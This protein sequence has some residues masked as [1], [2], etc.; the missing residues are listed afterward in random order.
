MATVG[1]AERSGPW[2][3]VKNKIFAEDEKSAQFPLAVTLVNIV[4]EL[5]ESN[6]LRN[7]SP[8]P[9]A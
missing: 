6:K 5:S 8:I 4:G 1:D 3:A 7:L 2:A 9:H